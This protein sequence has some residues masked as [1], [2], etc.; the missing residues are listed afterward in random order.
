[1]LTMTVKHHKSV[2][3]IGNKVSGTHPIDVHPPSLFRLL[4]FPQ[5]LESISF[6]QK[7][8]EVDELTSNCLFWAFSLTTLSCSSFCVSSTF[9]ISSIFHISSTF[10]AS[11]TF[12]SCRFDVLVG[13]SYFC[14]SCLLDSCLLG[15]CLTLDLLKILFRIQVHRN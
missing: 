14:L 12:C 15:C 13:H 5:N 8:K 9:H 6:Q 1:M 10:H 11:S 2:P 7:I 3:N 4:P